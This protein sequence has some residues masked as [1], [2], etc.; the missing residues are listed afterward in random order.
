VLI[1]TGRAAILQSNY[2]PWKG[3]FDLIKSVDHFVLYDDVQFTRR[4]WRN[5]NKIKTAHGPKWITVPVEVKGKY[6]QSIKETRIA[7]PGWAREH[8][9]T[10]SH[11]YGRAPYFAHLKPWLQE[12]YQQAAEKEFLSEVNYLFIS[13]ICEFL[14]IKT[15]LH[16]SSEFQLVDERSERLLTICRQLSAR[17]YLSGPAAKDYLDTALFDKHGIAVTWFD[18]DDYKEYEQLYPPFTHHVSI[19]DLLMSTGSD[20][21][22]FMNSFRDPAVVTR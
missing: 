5:R 4:D 1:L 15:K 22:S 14:G 10:I 8:W 11:C 12:L 16:W 13:A 21:P 19:I 2:I 18:Y 20:A 3:Y 6:F 9:A 7:S 17:E